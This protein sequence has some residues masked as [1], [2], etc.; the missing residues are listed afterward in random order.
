MK[1]YRFIFSER[2]VLRIAR[3]FLFWLVSYLL[4]FWHWFGVYLQGAN[5]SVSPSLSQLDLN[6]DLAVFDFAL[7]LSWTPGIFVGTVIYTYL[8]AYCL[9][10]V[11]LFRQRRLAFVVALIVLTIAMEV[12]KLYVSGFSWIALWYAGLWF[13]IGGPPIYCGI[14]VGLKML[15]TWDK[16]E[17][18]QIALVHENKQAELR[19]LKAQVHPHFLFNT[20]NNIYSFALDRS[21]QAEKLSSKLTA[22]LQYMINECQED[23]VPV[24]KEIRMIED[25]V[26][27]ERVRYG[28]NLDVRVRI[29]DNSSNAQ[30]EPFLLIPFLEN[31]FKHGTS[32]MLKSPWIKLDLIV[33]DTC[34]H[35]TLANGKPHTP[36]TR[37]MKAGI[38][39]NNVQKRLQLLY[40]EKYK[41][42]IVDDSTEFR[43]AMEVPLKTSLLAE[44]QHQTVFE[45]SLL[46]SI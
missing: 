13:V 2:V 44:P 46:P 40:G 33:D 5:S 18:E 23:L 30:I 4:M 27:L 35:F 10:P 31:S 38:G 34:L 20:L 15:K 21:P 7:V 8:V 32:Q 19:L 16:K 12:A 3:H 45:D 22:L 1:L 6:S 26:G 41:L 24:Q 25:Y 28:N 11:L 36:R 42:S 37:L 9:M 29:I 17:A 39:L 14:F 43:V